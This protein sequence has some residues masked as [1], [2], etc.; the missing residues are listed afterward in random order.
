VRKMRI[1][2]GC[3]RDHAGSQPLN[4]NM[5]PSVWSEVRMTASVDCMDTN[6]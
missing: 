2:V 1:V 5:G 3:K 6:E 4:M